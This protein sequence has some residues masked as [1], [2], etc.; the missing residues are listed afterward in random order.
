MPKVLFD[1]TTRRITVLPGITYLDVQADLYSDWKEWVVTSGSQFVSAFTTTGGDPLPGSQFVGR[2]Y[3]LINGWKL[4]PSGTLADQ[5][6][7]IDGNLF[8]D[9]G[10][11]IMIT[12]GTSVQLVKQIVSN[13]ASINQ[14]TTATTQ[15]VLTSDQSYQ[16]SSAYNTTGIIT[17]SLNTITGSLTV[18]S[19]SVSSVQSGVNTA[20]QQILIVSGG[21]SAVQ[22]T[23]ESTGGALTPTQATMLLEMYNLLGLD[24][25]KPLVVSPSQRTAGIDIDQTIT[26]NG[27][28]VTVTRVP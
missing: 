5:D 4:I 28:V 1:G 18:I 17:G 27:S 19:G 23:I 10:S 22:Q 15:S 14:V 6:L 12:S 2:Y 25:T 3:F 24:P 26:Q 21:V 8:S 20:N 9:D 16:L 11:S 7:T 13:L